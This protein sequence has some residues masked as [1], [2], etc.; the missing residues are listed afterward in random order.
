ML[1]TSYH[2]S[3]NLP[4]GISIRLVS[5]FIAIAAAKPAKV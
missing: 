1:R 3:P 5:L 2:P 4:Y